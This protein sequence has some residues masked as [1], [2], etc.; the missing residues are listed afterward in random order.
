MEN[1]DILDAVNEMKSTALSQIRELKDQIPELRKWLTELEKKSNRPGAGAADDIV[2]PEQAE[3]RK[4]FG[5]Y[6]RKGRVE[7][8]EELSVKAMN[9]G[10]D[11]NGGYLVVPEMDAAIDRIAETTS[12]MLRIAN[13][14]T[15]GTAKYEKLV[16]TAGMAMRRVADGATGGETTEPTFAKVAIEVF[17]AEVE[18]WVHNETLE[19]SRI[20]LETDL[21]ND[22]GIAFAEGGGSEFI[23]GNGV[24][25]ARGILSYS[26]VADAAY[27]WGSIGY[28]VTGGSGAFHTASSAV[29]SADSLITLQHALKAKYRA[30]ATWLMNSSTAGTVRKL[31]DIE[32]RH[33]WADS[34][35]VGQPPILL[36][37]PV[38]IDDN[39]PDVS[40]GSYSIAYGD[41]SRAYT[42][43]KRSGTTLIRDP[44]T[45]KGQTKFNFRRRF[46]GGI[47]HYEAIKLLKF[48]TS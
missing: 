11:P 3:Y 5:L 28:I 27:A 2:T 43:V 44:Y 4:A 42:I 39:M 12:P 36:G 37:S 24:G 9:T 20:D 32:G 29:N 26:I 23:T 8:L 45:S 21:A 41:F 25:K 22:A 1:K 48:A 46:S 16:K 33:V 35:L 15:I 18:P 7:G 6:L 10:S 30:N 34:L 14:V 13:V 19:D 17:T 40:A 38:A 47:T 31:K